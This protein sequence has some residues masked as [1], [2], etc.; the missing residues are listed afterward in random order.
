MRDEYTLKKTK[1]KEPLELILLDQSRTEATIRV[2]TS[3]TAKMRNALQQ[4][5]IEHQ[6]IFM[7]SHE[8]M[9]GID[10]AIMQHHLRA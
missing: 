9:P 6:D 1:A 5:L 7:W 2:G 4:L 3:M 10:L 8:D